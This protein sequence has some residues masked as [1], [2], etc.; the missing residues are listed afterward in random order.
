MIGHIRVPQ[1]AAVAFPLGLD[2]LSLSVPSARLA[3]L[4]LGFEA[5]PCSFSGFNAKGLGGGSHLAVPVRRAH[6]YL[7]AQG[8]L[9]EALAEVPAR[10]GLSP[11]P[12]SS[13]VRA[14]GV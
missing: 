1:T 14:P 4:E 11:V 8:S 6:S 5:P 13:P 12:I 9:L 10:L 2:T 3:A 7:G